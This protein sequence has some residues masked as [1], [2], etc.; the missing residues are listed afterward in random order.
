MA[1]V[2]GGS[3]KESS[4]RRRGEDET[5]GG[6]DCLIKER[7]FVGLISW[8]EERIRAISSSARPRLLLRRSVSLSDTVTFTGNRGLVAE[9]S[10]DE[11]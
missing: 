9:D 6:V 5:S 10:R 4:K 1:G 7:F 3:I 2:R 8:E 11:K